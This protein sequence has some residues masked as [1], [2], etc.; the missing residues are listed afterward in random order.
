MTMAGKVIFKNGKLHASRLRHVTEFGVGLLESLDEI[1]ETRITREE[2]NYLTLAIAIAKESNVRQTRDRATRKDALAQLKAMQRLK[3]ESLLHALRGCD[4]MTLE[5][6]RQAQHDAICDALWR[7]GVF[8]DVGGIEHR[9]PPDIDHAGPMERVQPYLPM[10]IAGLRAAIT[11]ALKNL[12]SDS[13]QED[14]A[15]GLSLVTRRTRFHPRVGAGNAEKHYQIDLARA[16]WALW[17]R[18]GP[19]KG[20]GAWR[21]NGTNKRSKLADLADVVFK[22]AGMELGDSRLVALLKK[23]K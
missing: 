21:T 19:S 7:D 10:G 16:C 3:D 22:E 12:E 13:A 9:T 18:H 4:R 6:I 23:A 8:V 15:P 20:R 14:P 2:W 17:E 5:A 11:D 1:L